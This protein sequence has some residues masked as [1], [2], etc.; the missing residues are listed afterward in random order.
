MALNQAVIDSGSADEAGLV[1]FAATPRPRM[2]RR[3]A[4]TSCWS[5]LMRAARRRSIEQVI[6]STFSAFG[7]DGGVNLFT[8]H[9]VGDTTNCTAG[10]QAALPLVQASTNS[11]NVVVFVSDGRC[12]NTG[13]GRVQR[14]D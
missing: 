14:G 12:D 1:V 4:A 2:C 6:G 11:N 10:L 9:N 8:F 3:R 5:R 13:G 7:G